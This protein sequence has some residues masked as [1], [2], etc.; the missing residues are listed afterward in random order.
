MKYFRVV[1]SVTSKSDD[2][3]HEDIEELILYKINSP[4]LTVT[5]IAVL[6]REKDNK[7]GT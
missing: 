3:D 1:M 4:N 5:E 7:K 6:Y 2:I